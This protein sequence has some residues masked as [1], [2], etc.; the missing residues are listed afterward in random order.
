MEEPAECTSIFV[1]PM[2]WMEAG[3][4][5]AILIFIFRPIHLCICYISY[6]Q[7]LIQ[8]LFFEL[9]SSRWSYGRKASV[10]GLQSSLGLLQLG[11][12]AVQ[13]WSLDQSCF[14]TAQKPIGRVPF[15]RQL[16]SSINWI[17]G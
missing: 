9:D 11:R 5:Q 17:V 2:K 14:S 12:Y 7:C 15:M 4:F 16:V 13:L 10:H 8:A 3:N 1:E 6:M